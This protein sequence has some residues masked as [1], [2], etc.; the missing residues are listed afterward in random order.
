MATL[1]C[2]D[3]MVPVARLAKFPVRMTADLEQKT[4][5]DGQQ[6]TSANFPRCTA[7][8]ARVSCIV[9]TETIEMADGTTEKSIKTET[10]SVTIWATPEEVAAVRA[11]GRAG[12]GV[13]LEGLMAGSYKGNTYLQATGLTANEKAQVK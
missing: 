4:D 13:R 9:G 7:W 3:Y 8:T 2:P 1:L 12:A 6:K 5:D 10:Y 11:A